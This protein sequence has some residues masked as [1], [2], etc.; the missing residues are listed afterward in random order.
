M[1]VVE[2]IL[3]PA[4]NQESSI[5]GT[6]SDGGRAY[7]SSHK[8]TDVSDEMNDN[9]HMNGMPPGTTP[10]S[11]GQAALLLSESTLHALV[12]KGVL[13]P[14]DALDIVETARDV[15]IETPDE[16]GETSQIKRSPLALLSAIAHSL[17][18]D[19]P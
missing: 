13:S 1:M 18:H 3:L 15:T 7:L 4:K 2:Y 12:E 16:P 9:H 17:G 6:G 19:V 5:S 10:D 14:A 8:A 11:Y